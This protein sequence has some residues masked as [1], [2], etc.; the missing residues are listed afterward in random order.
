MDSIEALSAG[1]IICI[2]RGNSVD[3]LLLTQNNEFYFKKYG[4]EAKGDIV[5]IGPKG[6]VKKGEDIK[7]AA[8]REV[9]EETGLDVKFDDKFQTETNYEFDEF[10]K[11][12]GK[13]MHFKKRVVY[14]L[15][16]IGPND[17]SRIRL[18]EEHTKYEI[19]DLKIVINDPKLSNKRAIFEEVN[20][21]VSQK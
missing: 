4:R 10:S 20:K 15:A 19:R 8:R 2:N 11:Q 16:I 3:V 21:Y 14:F 9:K 18:S 17:V 7:E 6:G 1:A 5:D 12:Y 13:V